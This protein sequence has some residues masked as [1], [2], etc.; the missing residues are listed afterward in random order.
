M[1]RTVT[2]FGS[3]IPKPG[4]DEY[5][6]ALSLGRILAKNNFNVC[7]GGYQGTMDA[8]SKGAR[9]YNV[10][11]IGITVDTFKAMPSKH[12]TEIIHTSTLIERLQKLIELGD[13]YIILPGGTGTLVE[14]SLVWEYLNKRI[15]PLKP[16]ACFGPMWGKLVDLIDARIKFEGRR[17]G[18][19]QCFDDI[20]QCANYIINRLKNL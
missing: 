10:R 3:S 1:N 12:L 19:I 18:L 8:V 17:E 13:A 16:V 20:Q 11:A 14:I 15:I 9:E 6:D 7:T 4:D 2:I 5:E